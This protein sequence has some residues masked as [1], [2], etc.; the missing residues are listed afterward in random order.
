M[1][2]AIA[3]R[4]VVGEAEDIFIIAVVPLE[5]DVDDDIVAVAMNGDRFGH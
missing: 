1:G 3:L 2:A 5:R 4:D